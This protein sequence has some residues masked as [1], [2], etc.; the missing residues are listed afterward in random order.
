MKKY[1]FFISQPYSFSILRPLQ[2]EILRRGDKVAW[3]FDGPGE[4]YLKDSEIKIN[5]IEEVIKYNP[6]AVFVPGNRVFDFFPG[7][8]VQV[9]H[10]FSI[11]KRSKEK[12]HFRIRGFFDLYCTQGPDTTIPFKQ[13]EKKHKY[14]KVVET[15]WSKL[16]PY[17]RGRYKK[18]KGNK[19]TIIYTSTFTKTLTS[20]P[21]LLEEIKKLSNK[22]DW[23]WIVTFH[24]RMAREI[25]EKYK[26]IQ[27]KNLQ[28]IETDNILPLMVNAD[29][30]ISDTS[31]V[32]SEFLVQNKP[33][34]T[35]K[36]NKPGSHLIN[37]EEPDKLL[38]KIKYALSY[39][40]ELMEDIENY[41]NLIHP[42][43]DGN[44]S[45]RVI[46][47][48]ENF[49]ENDFPNMPSK[50]LNLFRKFKMRKRVG[51]YKF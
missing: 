24:P 18:E 27:N 50:P 31:S 17:F 32:V 2:E 48:T 5:S 47:A 25:I 43:R 45:K 14:F 1:L 16:D 36:N 7:V 12:G 13:L 39:P 37:I 42:N 34:I 46:D 20:A 33:V 22:D 15:G 35:F 26:S 30:M 10:G 21:H 11:N 28:F 9:F 8:K 40:T 3:Y 41:S 49:I 4:Q 6:R 29:I 38:E 44:A 19:P 23:N 51:Y